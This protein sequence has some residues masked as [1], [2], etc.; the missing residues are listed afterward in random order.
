M[1]PSTVLRLASLVAVFMIALAAC[2]GE[3]GSD[4]ASGAGGEAA[5]TTEAAEDRAAVLVTRECGKV[6]VVARTEVPANQ[7]AMQ[8][9]DRVADVE[10]DLGGKFVTA[11][12]DVAADNGKKLAWLYYVN[13]EPA[14]KGAT[15]IRLESGDVEWWDL[16]NYEQE[17]A[18]VP[19]E[20]K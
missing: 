12:E 9:L 7:T 20:A 11:I 3:D 10:T 17:C 6:V 18:T 8:S 1:F 14:Q 2:G 19:P 16:H 5:A 15:E 4:T 13:G